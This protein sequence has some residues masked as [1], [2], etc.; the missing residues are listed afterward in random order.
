M[1]LN[2]KSD[3]AIRFTRQMAEL[4][5]E[6]LTGTIT[7]AVA[8]RLVRLR[9]GHLSTLDAD[10]DVQIGHPGGR[11]R[12]AD[13]PKWRAARSRAALRPARIPELAPILWRAAQFNRGLGPEERDIAY[14]ARNCS[15][16]FT[17]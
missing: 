14:R 10:V 9:A 8:E 16:P 15:H 17:T 4:T 11:P 1:G 3:G 7:I 2:I 6:S 12:H 13:P 5:G